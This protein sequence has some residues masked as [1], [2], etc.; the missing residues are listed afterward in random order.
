[1]GSYKD[2]INMIGN[3][4]HIPSVIENAIRKSTKKMNTGGN[5]DP[6]GGPGA[7]GFSGFSD[8]SIEDEEIYT[9]TGDPFGR[10]P[11]EPQPRGGGGSSVTGTG[12]GTSVSRM[13][14]DI[15]KK[16]TKGGGSFSLTPYNID[17]TI[18]S[19]FV[20]KSVDMYDDGGNLQD[21]GMPQ[22]NMPL[23]MGE[24]F[25]RQLFQES[26][27]NSDAVSSAGAT[28]MAQV[29]PD[30]F[31]DGLKKGYVPKGTKYG[32]LVTNP[33]LARQFQESY[34]NDLMSREWNVG[35]KSKS[36][37]IQQAKALAAYNLGPTGLLRNLDKQKQKGVDVNGTMDWISGL[38]K[39]TRDY[40]N[41]I[42]YGGSD[43]YEKNFIELSKPFRSQSSIMDAERMKPMSETGEIVKVVRNKILGGSFKKG[44][45]FKIKKKYI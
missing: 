12:V 43:V 40:V 37:R 16:A 35:E 31:I 26:R 17:T 41:Q 45:K 14:G 18:D 44:G 34:M 1:M 15:D 39:E 7:G 13:S 3:V 5:F 9:G 19:P 42:M 10:P 36:K 30:A 11:V 24:L 29:M 8:V 22:A 2:M 38:P 33:Q 28:S 4:K 20:S 25:L 27:F 23:D 6:V 32:D 21:I